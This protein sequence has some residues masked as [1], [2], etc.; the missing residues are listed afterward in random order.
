MEFLIILCYLWF[1][2]VCRYQQA[3]I[4]LADVCC[5]QM[6]SVLSLPNIRSSYANV[7]GHLKLHSVLERRIHIHEV[8]MAIIEL[9]LNFFPY[10]WVYEHPQTY[11]QLETYKSF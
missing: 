7:L 11:K 9:V 8:F 6:Q 5:C 1:Y 2:S 4:Y 10:L 3:G